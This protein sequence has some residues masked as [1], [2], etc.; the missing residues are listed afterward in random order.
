MKASTRRKRISKL[1]KRQ[2][3]CLTFL[4]D[5][6]PPSYEYKSSDVIREK[7]RLEK[8]VRRLRE[9]D[10][11]PDADAVEIADEYAVLQVMES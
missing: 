3:K 9:H 6:P 11:Q 1:L 7:D 10:V 4:C 2:E 8:T 5:C